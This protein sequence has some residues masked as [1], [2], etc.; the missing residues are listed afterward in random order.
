MARKKITITF[1]APITLL[2]SLTCIII[3]LVQFSLPP[4]FVQNYL[5]V[6]GNATSTTPFNY[7]SAIDYTSIFLHVFAH[8]SWTMLAINMF[9][10]LFLGP[11]IEKSYGKALYI[12]MIVI[13]AFVSGVLCTLFVNTQLL[14]AQ[15]ITILLF[16]LTLLSHAKTKTIP[17]N[18]IL[19]FLLYLF[20]IIFE[21][22]ADSS[23]KI[24]PFI[25]ALCASLFG[26]IDFFEHT[27]KAP[28]K[29]RSPLQ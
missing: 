18:L 25:G 22:N 6:G 14:G 19:L 3:F 24:V 11:E 26:F 7:T 27:K 29:K 13:T 9:S 16:V 17:F 2:F 28:R 10:L 20:F 5:S 1:E 4:H 8:T 15:G 23:E 21:T 12:L